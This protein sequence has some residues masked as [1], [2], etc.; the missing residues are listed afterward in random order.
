MAG[1]PPMFF[2]QYLAQQRYTFG[3][4]PDHQGDVDTLRDH[5]VEIWWPLVRDYLTEGRDQY[6]GARALGHPRY[7]LFDERLRG[8]EALMQK[9]STKAWRVQDSKTAWI[10]MIDATYNRAVLPARLPQQPAGYHRLWARMD[11][12]MDPFMYIDVSSGNAN[13]QIDAQDVVQLIQAVVFGEANQRHRG[14]TTNPP[15]GMIFYTHN[16]ADNKLIPVTAEDG[17]TRRCTVARQGQ[18]VNG[19]HRF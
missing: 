15:A 18:A 4:R 1:R 8:L 13:V 5:A 7:R 12:D 11:P 3:Q 2:S 17:A 6:A 9:T 10:E 19:A 16:Y 14:K